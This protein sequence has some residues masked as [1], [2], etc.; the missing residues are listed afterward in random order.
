MAGEPKATLAAVV[1]TMV[2]HE[3]FEQ[4]YNPPNKKL[5]GQG[6]PLW[7]RVFV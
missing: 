5:S 1:N 6:R 3:A 7:A 4:W 2:H